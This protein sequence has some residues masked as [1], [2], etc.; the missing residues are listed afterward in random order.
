MPYQTVG[1]RQTHILGGVEDLLSSLEDG[2][3]SLA[4]IKSSKHVAPIKV[5]RL[6]NSVLRNRPSSMVCVLTVHVCA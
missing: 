6:V 4:T 5:C 1:G 2:I 3:T